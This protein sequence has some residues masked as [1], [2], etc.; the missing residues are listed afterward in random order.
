V[1]DQGWKELRVELD[2]N[3][4]DYDSLSQ[5]DQDAIV[6]ALV[7][8]ATTGLGKTVAYPP[9]GALPYEILQAGDIE[10]DVRIDHEH[11]LGPTLVVGGFSRID[12]EVPTV[13]DDD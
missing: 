13:A 4:P 10:I 8:Y 11:P 2:E 3:D 5:D 9:P 6:K 12:T 1:P 7:R